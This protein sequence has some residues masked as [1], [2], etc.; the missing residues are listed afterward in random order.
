[1]NIVQ[2]NLNKVSTVQNRLHLVSILQGLLPSLFGC[3]VGVVE[4]VGGFHPNSTGTMP[5]PSGTSLHCTALNCTAW[6]CTLLHCTAPFCTALHPS[7]LH[8]PPLHFYSR[9]PQFM[10]A[11]NLY[12]FTRQSP[13]KFWQQV[14]QT[15]AATPPGSTLDHAARVLADRIK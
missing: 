11:K 9:H 15:R 3:V 2:Y 13:R 8:C 10:T 4:G 6:H 14:N 1:M 5:A 12:H 7:A